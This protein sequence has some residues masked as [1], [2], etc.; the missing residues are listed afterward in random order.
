M[1]TRLLASWVWPTLLWTSCQ[2]PET[3]AV[4]TAPRTTPEHT[5]YERTSSVADVQRFL[6]ELNGLPCGNRLHVEVA[7]RS[8]EDR[9]ILLVRAALP[10]IDESKAL[11]ALVIAN[12]H[13]G[14]VEGKESVQAILRE[15]ALGEHADL[16]ARFVLYFVPV[17]NV[18]G[19]ERID[20]K[21]RPEQNGPAAVGQ[22]AN[23]QGLD[24]NRDFVK[25]EAPETRAL[26]ALFQR[27]DPHLFFDLH[28]TDGSWHDYD[29]TYAP[30]LSTNCD[31]GV[32]ALSR[33]LLEAASSRLEDAE[34]PFHTFDYG[35][36]ET[37]DWDGGGAPSSQAEVRGFWTYDH[38]ARYGV[39][40]FGLRNRIGI[41]S[42]AYSNADFETRIEA[43]RAFVLAV[44]REAGHR[45]DSLRAAFHWAD[46]MSDGGS[47]D[48][49]TDVLESVTFGF[50]TVFAKPESLALRIGD[51]DR[52]PWPDGR[53]VR[54]ARKP[55]TA[56]EV[57][58]VFR[59]FESKTQV[60]L[61]RAWVVPNPPPAAT[62]LLQRHGI[63]F[64]VLTEARTEPAA[65]FAVT[66]KRKPKRPFQGHQEL[67]L[68]GDYG[69]PELT[70]LP[71]GSL[72]IDGCQRL[73]RLAATLLE[74][75]SE[76]SLSTW[77]YFEAVTADRYP[78]L[79]LH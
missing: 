49:A 53:G 62:E 51:C 73:A 36:F 11:R 7:G 12:I 6:F 76:D 3:S 21:N 25:A 47:L 33:T 16:L 14:E 67:V 74:P 79:R 58:P 9:E 55:S 40:Y 18:D 64:E 20:V 48:P 77:N 59:R 31:D 15:I 70:M 71:V 42:E 35:N 43:T 10:G 63:E 61:P 68:E 52:L 54:F 65:T 44:L 50:D 34:R 26:L 29:L 38:R 1:R 56:V 30:S 23:A 60:R 37:R 17:Y 32:A 8:H 19:N 22:R 41:L 5:A 78:V 13:A 69:D 24:L 2:R 75:Q 57:L 66:K 46:S 4:T 39:N 27:L 28:T 72:W 45:E